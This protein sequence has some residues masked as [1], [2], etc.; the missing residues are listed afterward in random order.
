MIILLPYARPDDSWLKKLG[1]YLFD[2]LLWVVPAFP[3]SIADDMGET[4][5]GL[6]VGIM[7]GFITTA[8]MIPIGSHVILDLNW[9]QLGLAEVA[10]YLVFGLLYHWHNSQ[11]N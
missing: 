1:I 6:L 8:I 4:Y 7:T 3:D 11:W 5:Q 10:N 2:M 9:W